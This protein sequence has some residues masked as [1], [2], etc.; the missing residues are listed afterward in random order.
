[1]SV[2][3]EVIQVE[4]S[5]GGGFGCYVAH[6]ERPNGAVLVVLQELFG[7]N[8][9]IRGIV[10]GFGAQGFLT[11][12]PDLFWRQEPA[13]ELDPSSAEARERATTLMKGLNP[14]QAVE[15]AATAIKSI[16]SRFVPPHAP[17]FAIGYCLGGK[18][19]YL[20]LAR[21][22]VAG[23]V[24]YY[25]VGI[26]G[27]LEEAKHVKGRLLLHIA[28][29]DH[30]CPPEAQ[31]K[32]AAAMAPLGNRVTVLTYGGVGHA[33]ARRGGDGFNEHAA[34]CAEQETLG[35]LAAALTP[36]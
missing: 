5:G 36:H 11:F 31:S 27:V 20:L 6:P 22:K 24:S 28:A 7:V 14:D 4:A 3:S 12:A 15:D 33:F 16:S 26:H 9:N 30:L 29:D 13:V 17:A 35:F 8:A 32:I 10:D 1:V 18:L 34:Q 25:G 21:G 2:H 19:A 23:A